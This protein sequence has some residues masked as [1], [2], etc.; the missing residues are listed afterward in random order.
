[1]AGLLMVTGNQIKNIPSRDVTVDRPTFYR[2][3]V[4]SM[5]SEGEKEEREGARGRSDAF[6]M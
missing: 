2:K 5:R 3:D 1:M 6:K 4:F